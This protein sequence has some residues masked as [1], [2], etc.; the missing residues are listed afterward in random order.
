MWLPIPC[1]YLALS[2]VSHDLPTSHHDLKIGSGVTWE[3]E[4]MP[5]ATHSRAETRACL[6]GGKRTVALQGEHW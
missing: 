6:L 4:K 5:G 2:Q 3:G 1:E